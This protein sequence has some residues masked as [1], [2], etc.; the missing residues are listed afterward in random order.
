MCYV[1][2]IECS[3]S[4]TYVG[5]TKDLE[6]RLRQHNNIIKGG[7]KYTTTQSKNGKTWKRICYIK[8]FPDWSET[9]KF[10][11][12]WKYMCKKVKQSKSPLERRFYALQL[13]LENEKSTSTS[14]PYSEWECE[15]E[16]VFECNEK[17]DFYN[18]LKINNL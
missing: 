18:K 2:L 11:W 6:K 15:P 8:N 3:D 1:Y 16:I 12:M 4:K 7:A 14:L 5:S 10:E 9:L 17:E 13:L